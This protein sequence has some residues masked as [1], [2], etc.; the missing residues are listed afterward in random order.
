MRITEKKCSVNEAVLQKMQSLYGEGRINSW[1]RYRSMLRALEEFAGGDIGFGDIDEEWLARCEALWKES[2]R[3][4]TTVGIYMKSLRSVYNA[5]MK[6]MGPFGPG[7]YCIP[8]QRSRK[9]ALSSSSLKAVLDWKG[10]VGDKMSESRD[11]WVFSYL[12]N[13]IN[14]KDM[15]QLKYSSIEDGEI[16][17]VRSKTRQS[18]GG[19]TV[20]VYISDEMWNIIRRRGNAVRSRRGDGYIF[21]YLDG[22]ETPM[23]LEGV[24]RSVI[25][26]CNIQMKKLAGE[27]KIPVFTTYSARHTFATVLKRKGVAVSYISESLGHTSIRT[28]ERYLAGFEQEDRRRYSAYLTDF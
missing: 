4:S 15:L 11:L 17:F 12:C 25:R 9:M 7:G 10:G 2:G 3:N 18:T 6:D 24:V 1:Y 27:L 21:R 19:M 26:D 22:T 14:F 23:Q 13:G 20:R 16:R 5:C 8:R 28:T